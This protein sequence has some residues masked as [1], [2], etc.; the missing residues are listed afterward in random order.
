MNYFQEGKFYQTSKV[1]YTVTLVMDALMKRHNN[2]YLT[3]LA[4]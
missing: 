2:M 4:L 3:S 1:S